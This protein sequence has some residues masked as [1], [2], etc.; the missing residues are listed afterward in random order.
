LTVTTL[1]MGG[2]PLGGFRFSVSER[3][4]VDT[5]LAAYAEGVRYFDT[6]PYYGYGRSEHI[7]GQALRTLDRDSFV[8]SSKVGRWMSPKAD[9]EDVPGWRKGGLL[10]KP[11]FDY[12]REGTLR[13][14]EQS[15]LRLGLNRIDIVL[16]HD[17]DVWTHGTQQAAD[18]RFKETMG[19]FFPALAE[20]R[21]AGV[22]KAIGVGLNESDMSL[23]FVRE[24]DIDCGA[25]LGVAGRVPLFQAIRHRPWGRGAA[26]LNG[27]RLNRINAWPMVQRRAKAAGITTE[28][29]NHSFRGTGITA[30]LENGG[31]LEKA[32]QMAAHAST[33]TTRLYDRREDRVTLDEVVKI[34][35]RRWATTAKCLWFLRISDSP[36]AKMRGHWHPQ[37]ALY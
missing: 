29:C 14:L 19:G 21:A 23:R 33:R 15:L 11:I 8:L 35:I 18:Q 1:G 31:T 22:I 10:F 7:Y 20:L 2:A 36:G 4:G 5:L 17:V 28:V 12:S 30:Y 27:E 16:I 3:Q 34:N 13:S 25:Q 32:R 9:N 24:A 37:L 6:A 26:E